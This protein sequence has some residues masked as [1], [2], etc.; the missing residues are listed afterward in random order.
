MK[1][2]IDVGTSAKT[3]ISKYRIE[4]FDEKKR[5]I[6]IRENKGDAVV[7]KS[8]FFQALQYT[9]MKKHLTLFR[10][11]KSNRMFVAAS[12]LENLD[13]NTN[14]RNCSFIDVLFETFIEIQIDK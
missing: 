12:L 11:L 8:F 13:K 4:A 10:M 14:W 6:K 9:V 2:T 3:I 7:S 5:W 1:L